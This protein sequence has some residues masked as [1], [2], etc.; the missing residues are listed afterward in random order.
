MKKIIG[1]LFTVLFAVTIA[2]GQK[3][4][5]IRGALDKEY[6]EAVKLFKVANGDMVEIAVAVPQENKKFGFLFFPDYEGFY[7]LGTGNTAGQSDNLIFYFK[8]GDQLDLTVTEFSYALLGNKNSKENQV[9]TAWHNEINILE[10]KAFSWNKKISTFVDFFPE[11]ERVYEKSKTFHS[12]VKTGNKKFDALLPLFIKWDVAAN[13]TNYLNTPR[14]VHPA[15][16]EYADYYGSLSIQDFS[17]DASLVYSLPW[18]NRTLAAVS[19]VTRRMDK[20][21]YEK[22][23]NN[24]IIDL[25]RFTNDTL[26]ADVVLNY[27]SRQKEY[28]DY[29]EASDKFKHMIITPSQKQRA[30]TILNNMAQL[31]EGDQGFNF[32]FLDNKGNLVQFDDLKGKVLLVDV[33]ATWCGPCKAEIPSLK[34]IEKDYEGTDLQVVSISL[35][36][37]KDKEK[38]LKMIQ[39]DNLGGIQLF[40]SGWG[41]FSNY[42]KIRGIPRFMLFDRSG[43]IITIDSPRPSNP[44]LRSLLDKALA[45]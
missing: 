22:G 25:N 14:T 33:W 31:A 16:E 39:D 6:A 32:E 13:A 44:I 9:L 1:I 20:V 37:E 21:P 18:G 45:K 28:K 23:I 30:A 3:S 19:F 40:A 5:Q 36:E 35:D 27:L 17:R 15:L 10:D 38:W 41:D 12:K 2:F 43:K 24:L 42:Y 26:K 4:V 8:P 34:K 11:L 7:A 29:K